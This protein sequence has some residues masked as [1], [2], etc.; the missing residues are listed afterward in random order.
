MAVELI[1]LSW[2]IYLVSATRSAIPVV[3]RWARRG[4]YY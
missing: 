4:D 3:N 2:F 1:L